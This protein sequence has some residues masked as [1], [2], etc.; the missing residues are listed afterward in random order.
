MEKD[1]F[2]LSGSDK[3]DRLSNVIKTLKIKGLYSYYSR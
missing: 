1:N 2:L 3:R